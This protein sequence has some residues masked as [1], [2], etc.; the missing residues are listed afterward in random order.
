MTLLEPAVSLTDLGLAIENT[1]FTVLLA[2]RSTLLT[3]ARR[4][5]ILFFVSLAL[6]AL[7]G[8]VTH[9]FFAD[10]SLP[11]H[12]QLWGVTLLSMG[13]MALATVALA[14][15]L[16][17]DARVA[18]RIVWGAACLLVLY[19]VAVISG[20]RHFG[21]AIAAY[22]PAMVFLLIAFVNRLGKHHRRHWVLGIAGLVLTS[23]AAA[24]QQLGVGLH[25]EYFNHNALYHVIQAPALWMLYLTARASLQEIV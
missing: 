12:Q 7:L 4:W 10:K 13:L 15:L 21:L 23:I 20:Y 14:A 5:W 17:F 16:T 6:A 19:S 11:L 1:V 18:N 22:A 24:L 3:S 25:P 2:R 9:G 8:F